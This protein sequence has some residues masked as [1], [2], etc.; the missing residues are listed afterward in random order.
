M[1][2]QKK[3]YK[4]GISIYRDSIFCLMFCILVFLVTTPVFAQKDVFIRTTVT[5]D[6]VWVGQKAVMHIDVLAQNGWAQIKK[7][8]DMKIKGA[9]ML[10]V[11]TQGTRLNE[12]ID[13]DTYTGQRYELLIF[14]Q[15]GGTIKIPPLPVDVQVKAWGA[16]SETKVRQ[17]STQ[18]VALNV[19]IPPGAKNIKGL[20]SSTELTV[21]QTWE[22]DAESAKAGD[23][24][25]RI[26]TLKALD[27][28]GMAFTP[29]EF[30]KIAGVGVYPG[31][32]DVSDTTDRGT[33]TGKR[34][35]KVTYVFEQSGKFQIPEIEFVWWDSQNTELKRIELPGKKLKITGP[36]AIGKM[37]QKKS[38][39]VWLMTLCAIILALVISFILRGRLRHLKVSWKKRREE[40]EIVYFRNVTKAAHSGD[41]KKTLRETMRWLDRINPDKGLAR[42]DLF[43]NAHGDDVAKKDITHFMNCMQSDDPIPHAPALINS[44]KRARRHWKQSSKKEKRAEK[45]LPELNG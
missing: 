21:G 35:E 29:L 33:L 28:S 13:G 42:L 43:L 8:G 4:I 41:A 6:E 15:V 11:E 27:V 9:Y 37:T 30:Q 32:P 44:L 14:P 45:M 18:G 39:P 26:I 1:N 10:R 19:K 3:I 31:Q 5:P 2:R 23:A 17:M 25:T 24:I 38:V 16:D 40:R 34:I 12:T 7:K 36:P 20:I 22:P